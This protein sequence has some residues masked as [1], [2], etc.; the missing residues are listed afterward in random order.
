MVPF[1][2]LTIHLLLFLG[3]IL[4][5]VQKCASLQYVVHWFCVGKKLF[6]TFC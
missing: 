5:G 3:H 6:L 2:F 1:F 4:M